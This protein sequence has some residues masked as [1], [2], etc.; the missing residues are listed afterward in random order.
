MTQE[1]LKNIFRKYNLKVTYGYKI[2][3][4]KPDIQV[5]T[6]TN[7]IGHHNEWGIR[8]FGTSLT[9][10]NPIAVENKLIKMIPYYKRKLIEM[11]IEQISKDFD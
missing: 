11:K 6:F 9:V 5:G 1:E 2:Y 8:F 7:L 10:T 4:V 3:Y